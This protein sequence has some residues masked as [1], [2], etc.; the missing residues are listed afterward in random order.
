MFLELQSRPLT[1][2]YGGTFCDNGYKLYFHKKPPDVWNGPKYVF[3][4]T[5]LII[6]LSASVALI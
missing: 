1:N 4:I 5:P 3:I 6:P 2:M